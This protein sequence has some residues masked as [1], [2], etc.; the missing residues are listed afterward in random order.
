[1]I[2][3]N[4]KAEPQSPRIDSAPRSCPKVLTH[5]GQGHVNAQY[6]GEPVTADAKGTFSCAVHGVLGRL[7]PPAE[8]KSGP[9]LMCVTCKSVYFVGWEKVQYAT[10]WIRLNLSSGPRL[11]L[12]L[13]KESA[14]LFSERTLF[15]A[16]QRLSVKVE[17]GDAKSRAWRLQ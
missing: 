11:A 16:A 10:L 5:Y 7:D 4:C 8:K 2:C 3:L 12:E 9:S 13:R 15:R 6:C 1:M 14:D 17:S